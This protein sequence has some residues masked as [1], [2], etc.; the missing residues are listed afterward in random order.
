MDKIC[1][2]EFKDIPTAPPPPVPSA[3]S[4]AAS[5]ALL[6][7]ARHNGQLQPSVTIAI[8]FLK[9]QLN[10]RS[11]RAARFFWLF[12]YARRARSAV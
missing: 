12:D 1:G 10:N 11:A 3:A 8:G 7:V 5:T 6:Y 2:P 9:G 4:A